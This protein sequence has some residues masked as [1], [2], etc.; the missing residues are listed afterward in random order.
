MSSFEM[1]DH[2]TKTILKDF[3]KVFNF[4]ENEMRKIV[5]SRQFCKEFQKEFYKTRDDMNSIEIVVETKKFFM[6]NKK[7]VLFAI[8]NFENDE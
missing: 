6:T 7:N 1:C 3:K 5:T 4:I 8:I 2:D